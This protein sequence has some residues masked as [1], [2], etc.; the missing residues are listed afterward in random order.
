[1]KPMAERYARPDWVRRLVAMGDSLGEGGA[2]RLVPLDADAMLEGAAAALGGG[3]FPDFGDPRWESRFRELVAAVDAAPLHAVG[4]L[5]TRQELQRSLRARLLLARAW[6]A[7]PALAEERIEAPVIVTGPARSGTS[8]LFELLWL[9]PTLRGPLA[10]EALHPLPFE[11]DRG[12]AD[13]RPAVTECEQELWADLQPEFA[14]MHELRSD[15]PVECVTLTQPCFCGPH[16]SM[17]VSGVPLPDMAEMYAF[18]RRIL[19]VLQREAPPATWLLK[20]P[21]HLSTLDLAFATYPDAWIVQ[22]HRDPAK[23]MPSTLSITATVQWMRADRVDLEGLRAAIDLAFGGALNAVAERRAKGELPDRFV[24]VH[25]QELCRDP[26]TTLGRA[27][28]RMGRSFSGEH[29]DAALRYL[30]EKPRGKYGEHRY[31]PEEW[32]FDRRALHEQLA[33]YIAHFGVELET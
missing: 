13:R 20:T 4:R 9:D 26:V 10:W 31:T 19:Q 15:L 6:A 32:G 12:A 21:A 23:T 33:P 27:Y 5:V 7:E 30:D 28:E 17:V 22:T 8:I 11:E 18:H 29:A 1:V 14:A 24:D 3:P 25:F 16:W 2:R